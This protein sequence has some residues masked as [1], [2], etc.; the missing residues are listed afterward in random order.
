MGK[1]IYKEEKK[2]FLHCLLFEIPLAS[3]RAI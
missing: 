1:K 2:K 3:E